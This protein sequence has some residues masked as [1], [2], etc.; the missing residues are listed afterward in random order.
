MPSRTMKTLSVQL[1]L[2]LSISG[3]LSVD[4]ASAATT[5]AEITCNVIPPPFTAYIEG[6]TTLSR[7]APEV[8]NTS[9]AIILSTYSS[10]D[11]SKLRIE[12]SNN[13]IY[14]MTISPTYSFVDKT[15]RR[16]KVDNL[17]LQNTV[18]TNEGNEQDIHMSGTLVECDTQMPHSEA[19]TE[20]EAP[21]I[22][23]HF[24]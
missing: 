17:Q 23:I 12:N 4:P 24:N 21:S 13:L 9:D 10:N 6:A 19:D 14:S 2:L 18:P 7:P 3:L 15:G 1:L 11:T 22:T 20:A 8:L 5:A 16:M